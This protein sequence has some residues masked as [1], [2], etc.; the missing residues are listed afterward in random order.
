MGYNATSMQVI[1]EKTGLK[2]GSIYLAFGN[3]EGLF[4][5]SLNYYAQQS[6]SKATSLMEGADSIGESICLILA[7]FV[8]DAFQKDYCSCFLVKSQLELSGTPDLQAH[9]I[10]HLRD[11]EGVYAHFL[12]RE[13][14]TEEAKI[15]ATSLM[16]HIFGIRVY[17]YHQT[18]KAQMLASLKLGL[19]WLPWDTLPQV[20]LLESVQ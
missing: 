12:E 1:F 17:G 4:K 7:G 11:I 16:M 18:T 5:E 8:D 14:S 19:P 20:A 15:K 13:Y 3:K 2:P 6:I 10:G 9:A